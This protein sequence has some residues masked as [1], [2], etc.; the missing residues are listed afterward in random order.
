MAYIRPYKSHR[1]SVE[2]LP[3]DG[4]GAECLKQ[5]FFASEE[6]L[7][8]ALQKKTFRHL[9][10]DIFNVLSSSYYKDPTRRWLGYGAEPEWLWDSFMTSR[11]LVKFYADPLAFKYSRLYCSRGEYGKY[12]TLPHHWDKQALSVHD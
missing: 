3:G 10:P 1:P 4:T 11:D 9:L 12:I 6:E 7:Q 5:E 8:H 2:I